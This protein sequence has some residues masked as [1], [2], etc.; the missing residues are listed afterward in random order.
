MAR[1]LTP[2]QWQ[3]KIRGLEQNNA[4]KNYLTVAGAQLQEKQNAAAGARQLGELGAGNYGH[5]FGADFGQAAKET[6][7]GAFGQAAGVLV[8]QNMGD[9]AGGLM[10]AGS[11]EREAGDAANK[12]GALAEARNEQER[13]AIMGEAGKA[14]DSMN[15]QNTA[16]TEALT[17]AAIG[18]E[19]ALDRGM[20]G[21]DLSGVEGSANMERNLQYGKSR[22]EAGEQLQYDMMNMEAQGL[23]D[24]MANSFSDLSQNKAGAMTQAW[25]DTLGG[26]NAGL[27]AQYGETGRRQMELQP[28]VNDYKDMYAQAESLAK[29]NPNEPV[30]GGGQNGPDSEYGTQE[31]Y[32][33]KHGGQNGPAATG[34]LNG[35]GQ[36]ADPNAGAAGNYDAIYKFLAAQGD[37]GTSDQSLGD[38]LTVLGI[39]DQAQIR[40]IQNA[41]A[42]GKKRADWAQ[43]LWT[44]LGNTGSVDKKYQQR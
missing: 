19:S 18:Q 16:R 26:L 12:A 28:G 11:W 30:T 5:S 9:I 8:G 42:F 32:N 44:A 13:T 15:L 3:E 2:A 27:T 25:G 4:A 23:A 33:R 6:G 17:D 21:I 22:A 38:V 10:R 29:T 31:D 24:G 7:A 36:A 39:T 43:D 35:A 40:E 14:A 37:A 34:E 1:Q 20:Q 41:T